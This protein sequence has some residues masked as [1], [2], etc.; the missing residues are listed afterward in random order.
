MWASEHRLRGV[1]VGRRHALTQQALALPSANKPVRQSRLGAVYPGTRPLGALGLAPGHILRV[2][3][4]QSPPPGLP[5]EESR[6]GVFEKV[7]REQECPEES[8]F[9]E[10]ADG[11]AGELHP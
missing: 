1:G 5:T 9:Q 11:R 2:T 3:I 4:A 6:R 8:A 7:T 10:L